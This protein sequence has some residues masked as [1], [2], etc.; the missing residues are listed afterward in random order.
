M[1]K[2]GYRAATDPAEVVDG[3]TLV[4]LS[5]FSPVSNSECK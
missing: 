5:E 3:T 4:T 2:T 1:N